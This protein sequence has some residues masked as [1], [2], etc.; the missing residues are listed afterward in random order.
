MTA[1]LGGVEPVSG[2]KHKGE[3]AIQSQIA[4]MF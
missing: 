1:I 2:G 3:D 4:R